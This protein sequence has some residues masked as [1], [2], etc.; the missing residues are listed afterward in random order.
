MHLPVAALRHRILIID[1]SHV[2]QSLLKSTLERTFY[3]FSSAHNG[4]QGYQL[5]QAALPDLILLEAHMP[6][7]DG[8]AVCRLLKADPHT[9]HIP[10][11]F[12]SAANRPEERVRGL[13]AGAVDYVGKPCSA[14]E[15]SMRI[16]IHLK[17]A[18]LASGPTRQE[19][20]RQASPAPAGAAEDVLVTAAKHYI[21]EHL[22]NLPPLATI[23]RN[24][25]TYREKLS[26]LFRAQTGM[27]VFEF[28]RKSRIAQGEQLLAD[29]AMEVQDIAALTGFDSGASFTTAFRSLTGLTPSAYRRRAQNAA[30][31][32]RQEND[33]RLPERADGTRKEGEALPDS[34]G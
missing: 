20:A 11:I 32:M 3:Q 6:D 33:G 12:L 25:G 8:F 29:S 21:L 22:A 26:P 13:L 2:E 7:L 1:A 17:L 19:A 30:P 9:Q 23:A 34:A 10:V 5:A 16:Q 15:L 31:L 27:S 14:Q 24:V 28:I 4:A 18:R